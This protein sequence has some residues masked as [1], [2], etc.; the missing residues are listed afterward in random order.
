MSFFLFWKNQQSGFRKIHLLSQLIFFKTH[1]VSQ[2]EKK[3]PVLRFQQNVT[4]IRC[5]NKT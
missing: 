2:K 3:Y 1:L 4:I 5:I